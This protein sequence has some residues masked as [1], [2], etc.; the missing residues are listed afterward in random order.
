MPNGNPNYGNFNQG[1]NYMNPGQQ[2]MPGQAP[3]PGQQPM[4][5]Q[6]MPAQQPMMPQQPAPV[7]PVGA[8]AGANAMLDKLKNMPCGLRRAYFSLAL[9]PFL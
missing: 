2:P 7:A 1:V 6:P 8:P 9:L 3:M 4:P 5:G